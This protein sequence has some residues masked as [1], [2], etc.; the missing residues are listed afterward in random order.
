MGERIAVVLV[1]PS[2][3]DGKS[4]VMYS[5]NGGVNHG[6][7]DVVRAWLKSLPPCPKNCSGP[8]DRRE[9]S[10]LI[11]AFLQSPYGCMVDRVFAKYERVPWLDWGFWE[12]NVIT[13]EAEEVPRGE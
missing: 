12:I 11:P 10:A 5:H 1:N 7:I 3:H 4:V 9:V 13:L 2:E 8:I 6:F